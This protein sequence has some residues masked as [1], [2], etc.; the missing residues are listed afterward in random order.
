MCTDT[1]AV[2]HLVSSSFVRELHKYRSFEVFAGEVPPQ[3]DT[4]HLQALDINSYANVL[5]DMHTTTM[6]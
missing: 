4:V 5:I 2:T 1:N 3:P 6:V